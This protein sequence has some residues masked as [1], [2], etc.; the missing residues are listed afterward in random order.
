MTVA[1]IK[2]IWISNFDIFFYFFSLNHQLI[3]VRLSWKNWDHWI[4]V[5]S[6]YETPQQCT[7]S[8]PH[9]EIKPMTLDLLPKSLTT[10]FM[11]RHP[12]VYMSIINLFTILSNLHSLCAMNNC[13][14]SEIVEFYRSSLL[15][16]TPG[17]ASLYLL[18]L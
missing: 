15:I 16:W 11:S 12:M 3:W 10:R 18:E 5:S 2:R 7:A 9:P 17:V 8:T 1:K 13:F 14:T 4:T 6:L